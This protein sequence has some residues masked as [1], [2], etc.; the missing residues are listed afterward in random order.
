MVLDKVGDGVKGVGESLKGITA[1]GLEDA[2]LT[3]KRWSVKHLQTHCQ[4]D[5]VISL[6]IFVVSAASSCMV[7]VTL[8]EIADFQRGYRNLHTILAAGLLGYL[9]DRACRSH[10]CAATTSVS[11]TDHHL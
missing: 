10:W 8:D 4:I 5:L 6:G 9:L 7:S 1:H 3:G 2:G 11:V